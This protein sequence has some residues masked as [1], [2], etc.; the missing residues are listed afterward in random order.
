MKRTLPLPTRKGTLLF[1]IESISRVEPAPSVVTCPS[2]R[3]CIAYFVFSM[4]GGRIAS[5]FEYNLRYSRKAGRFFMTS[6]TFEAPSGHA[7]LKKARIDEWPVRRGIAD[8]AS[9]SQLCQA[10]TLDV[11]KPGLPPAAPV[12]RDASHKRSGS[13]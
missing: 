7:G 2:C 12:P 10:A 9:P 6:R 11:F 3:C 1:R 8:N 4:H 5:A 13:L